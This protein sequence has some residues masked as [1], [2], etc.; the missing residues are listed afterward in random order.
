MKDQK[1]GGDAVQRRDVLKTLGAGAALAAGSSREL[2]AQ[3]VNKSASKAG[4]IDVHH[5]H[6]PPGVNAGAGL[7]GGGAAAGGAGRGAAPAAG[8]HV[9]TRLDARAHARTDG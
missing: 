3:F 1:F 4:R 6:V 7:G 9:W 5:H 2:F 8:E